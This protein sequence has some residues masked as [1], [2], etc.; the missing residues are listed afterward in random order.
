M[1]KQ[2]STPEAEA[3]RWLKD[4]KPKCPICSEADR[5]QFRGIVVSRLYPASESYQA[6]VDEPTARFHCGKCHFVMYVDA[7][8]AGIPRAPRI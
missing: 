3:E 8:T 1:S 4:T 6:T 7:T 2:Q 5:W